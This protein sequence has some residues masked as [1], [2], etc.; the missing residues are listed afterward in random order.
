MKYDGEWKL[1]LKHGKAH[2]KYV[3]GN[4]YEGEYENGLRN[5][6]GTMWY[7]DGKIYVGQFKDDKFHGFGT[8]R[9]AKGNI[10]YKGEYIDGHKVV[11]NMTSPKA[12]N[13][14]AATAEK[15]LRGTIFNSSR[16]TSRR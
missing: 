4:M 15:A 13:S 8:M 6:E 10:I 12:R 1:D 11:T 2:C 5:G 16:S 14:T 9:S 7:A 3:D